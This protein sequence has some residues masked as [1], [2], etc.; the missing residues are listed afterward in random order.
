[1]SCAKLLYICPILRQT[2]S[3]AQKRLA[4][5][6]EWMKIQIQ[7]QTPELTPEERFPAGNAG[8]EQVPAVDTRGMENSEDDDVTPHDLLLVIALQI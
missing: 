1:M 4:I 8:E 7:I 2:A 6:D 5:F 3:Y